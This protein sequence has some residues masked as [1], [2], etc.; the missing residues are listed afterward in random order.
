MDDVAFLPVGGTLLLDEEGNA[1]V[2]PD[3][4]RQ[5]FVSVGSVAYQEAQRAAQDDLKAAWQLKLCWLD[6]EQ[7][8]SIRFRGR[9]YRIYRAYLNKPEL[10]YELYLAERTVPSGVSG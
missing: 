10:V 4:W 2:A 1:S 6:Y 5:V 3:S 8:S 7:E 9:E